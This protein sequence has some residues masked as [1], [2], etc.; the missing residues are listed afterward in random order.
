MKT[1]DDRL[2]VSVL[3]G[4]L[5]SGKT[6]LLNRLLR[7]PAMGETAVIINEFGEI[8]I[9]DALVVSSSDQVTLLASGCLCCTSR[10]D[11]I[12]TLSEL[13]Q[14][15]ERGEV[16]QFMRVVIETTGLADPAPILQGLMTDLMMLNYFRMGQVVTVVDSYHG[17]G[18]LD[19]QIEAVKQ[20]A[21]ADRIV[22]SKSD[23]AA[24][25]AVTELRARLRRL[26]PLAPMVEAVLGE[27]EP[28]LLFGATGFNIE[29]KTA[30]VRSW[31]A[32]EPP[33]NGHENKVHRHGHD[34]NRHDE[35][36]QAHCLSFATPLDWEVVAGWLD[37]LATE[38]GED[39]L[40]VKGLLNVRGQ[41]EPVVI[42]GV[43]HLFHPPST[44][45]AWPDSD[46][47][48]R[49]VFIVRDLDRAEVEAG[50]PADLQT[51]RT[52]PPRS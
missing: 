13:L 20:A 15:R 27:V 7:H 31:L 12:E 36:I 43:H 14:K 46:R 4:F 1:Q 23:I 21:V 16:P 3:T 39:L 10:G 32:P 24:P 6:T 11:L 25:D 42:Q 18:T 51:Y 37:R 47:R 38:H 2:P 50:A 17:A 29:E 9:D 26:N 30:E 5:G 22:L 19:E 8:G 34:P 45:P 52:S 48:S 49:L 35:R 41:D 40:R 44:L 28:T 33:S